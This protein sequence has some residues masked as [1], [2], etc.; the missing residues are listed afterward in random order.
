MP[1]NHETPETIYQ[2]EWALTVLRSALTGLSEEYEASGRGNV[3]QILRPYLSWNEGE[4]TY[5][6]AAKELGVSVNTVKS[7]VSRLRQRYRRTLRAAIADTLQT[8]SADEIDGEI[9]HLWSLL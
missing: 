9:R 1:A 6:D 2:R 5:A 7:G 3:F 4:G 8:D